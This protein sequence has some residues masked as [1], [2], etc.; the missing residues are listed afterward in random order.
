MRRQPCVRLDRIL[1]A[2]MRRSLVH[3]VDTLDGSFRGPLVDRVIGDIHHEAL[4]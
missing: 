2:G 1:A 4:M 3:V